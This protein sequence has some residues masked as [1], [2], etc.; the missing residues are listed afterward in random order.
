MQNMHL[1]RI[2]LSKRI[3]NSCTVT[4][5]RDISRRNSAE[6]RQLASTSKLTLSLFSNRS[7]SNF[8]VDQSAILKCFNTCTITAKLEIFTFCK[9][10]K[11]WTTSCS[12]FKTTRWIN[13]NYFYFIMAFLFQSPIYPLLSGL[14][15]SCKVVTNS[16]FKAS[17]AIEKLTFLSWLSIF[18]KTTLKSLSIWIKSAN[19]NFISISL[20]LMYG[21][22]GNFS[23]HFM[24][25]N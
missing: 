22:G 11:L 24:K 5:W 17:S 8:W 15:Q 23:S 12:C 4:F 18:T 2:N 6:S 9:I 21:Y 7:L 19:Y 16:I 3:L 10:L 25:S 14:E 13:M 1:I 20:K